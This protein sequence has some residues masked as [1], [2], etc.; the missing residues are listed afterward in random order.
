[1]I[2]VSRQ[3]PTGAALLACAALACVG[4]KAFDINVGTKEPI[5][6]D[7]IKVDLDM[8]VDVYQYDGK[9]DEKEKKAVANRNEAAKRI[10]DRGAEIQELKN[11]RFVGENSLGLLSIRNRPAGDYGDY[12]ARTVDAENADRS[13]L[14]TDIANTDDRSL[15]EVRRD[16]WERRVS[17]SFEGEWIEEEGDAPDT[18]KWVEK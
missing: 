1:M 2:A 14:M 8:R 3:L 13:F 17:A 7:P 9:S 18:F 11:N 15:A 12:V 10:R 4:C 16:Q 5:K 6:L